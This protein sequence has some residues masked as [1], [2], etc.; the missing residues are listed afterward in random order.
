VFHA[1]GND[2]ARFLKI[3]GEMVLPKLRQR[4]G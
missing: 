2:Q 4:F 1:P 3:Y